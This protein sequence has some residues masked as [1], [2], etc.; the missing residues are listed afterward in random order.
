MNDNP[1]NRS[2]A[3][4]GN[5]ISKEV[6]INGDKFD[7]MLI[8]TSLSGT[9]LFHIISKEDILQVGGDGVLCHIEVNLLEKAQT[10]R[11]YKTDISTVS[12]KD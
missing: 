4:K 5:V 9:Y 11:D 1:M 10:E 3:R 6:Y 2:T 12:S 7:E 8:N